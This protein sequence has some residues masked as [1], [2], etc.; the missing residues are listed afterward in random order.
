[1]DLVRLLQGWPHAKVLQDDQLASD[2]G[3]K[4]CHYS[5]NKVERSSKSKG[6]VPKPEKEDISISG[7]K[8][9]DESEVMEDDSNDANREVETF[10]NQTR[11]SKKK[12]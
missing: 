6:Y 11:E 3:D 9:E 8:P 4:T 12:N 1:V 2:S 7:N 10:T 5:V